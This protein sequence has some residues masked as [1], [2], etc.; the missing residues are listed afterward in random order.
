MAQPTAAEALRDRLRSFL[1]FLKSKLLGTEIDLDRMA[2]LRRLSDVRIRQFAVGR[3]RV[4]A[5]DLCEILSDP[6]SGRF[7]TLA[8]D[9]GLLEEGHLTA[10]LT[11]LSEEM[12]YLV[13][14][15]LTLQVVGPARMGSVVRSFVAEKGKAAPPPQTTT[16]KIRVVSEKPLP[17]AVGRLLGKE[18]DLWSPSG[19]VRKAAELLSAADP[20]VDAACVEIERDPALA[21]G[22]LRIVNCASIGQGVRIGSLKR[23]AVGLGLPALR[24]AVRMAALVGRLGRPHPEA[25]LDLKAFWS[26]SLRVAHA[27]A[28]VARSSRIGNPDDHFAAG[29]MHDIGKLVEYQ[30][31]REPLR[32]ILEA[33]RGGTRYPAAERATLGVDHAVIG[34]C[35]LERWRFPTAV[36]EAVRHHLDTPEQLEELELPREA[37]VVASLC[38][39]CRSGKLPPGYLESWCGLLGLTPEKAAILREQALQITETALAELGTLA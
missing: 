36:V 2:Q 3:A 31:L 17:E 24:S 26:H 5:R 10:A 12:G 14:A 32:R 9:A 1:L 11:A 20:S 37:H 29:F 39:I 15:C 6:R 33:V 7:D 4:T 28:T 22:V 8:A 13:E 25:P 18:Q 35:L 27:A 34:A 38:H 16:Q 19:A 21:A 23:A 30:Y